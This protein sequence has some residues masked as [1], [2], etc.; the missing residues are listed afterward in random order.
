MAFVRVSVMVPKAG[1]EVRVGELL[2]SL[3]ALYVGKPGFITAYRLK[4]GPHAGAPRVGR[5]TVWETAAD[6]DRMAQD[7][8]DMSLQSELMLAVEQEAHEE[9][10]FE[11]TEVS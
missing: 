7:S 2:D 9:H 6:A 5:I 11:G 10:S 8:T 3:M 4:P 1:R